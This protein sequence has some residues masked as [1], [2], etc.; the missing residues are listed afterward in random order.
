MSQL[1][2]LL[3]W[4]DWNIEHIGRHGVLPEEAQYIVDHPAKGYPQQIGDGK[5]LVRGRT[6]VGRYLQVIFIEL[7]DEAIGVENLN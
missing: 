3:I 5:I 4:I 6:L 2:P 7:E 1:R